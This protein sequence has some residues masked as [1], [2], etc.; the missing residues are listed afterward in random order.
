MVL[1]VQIPQN[2]FE[3]ELVYEGQKKFIVQQLLIS[4]CVFLSSTQLFPELQF[5]E[6]N[7]Y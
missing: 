5:S 2:N 6:K 4:N 7:C 1:S 3:A